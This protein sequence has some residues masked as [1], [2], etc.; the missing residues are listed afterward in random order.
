MNSRGGNS[1]SSV[2]ILANLQPYIASKSVGL[3]D[4]VAGE[5]VQLM[6]DRRAF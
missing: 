1:T 4:S 2:L 6:G 5:T 3:S